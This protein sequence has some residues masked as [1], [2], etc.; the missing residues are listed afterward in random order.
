MSTFSVCKY[1][2]YI[3]YELIT[4]LNRIFLNH[5]SHVNTK[6]RID[7]VSSTY[8]P[9]FLSFSL[10]LSGSLILNYVLSLHF[11]QIVYQDK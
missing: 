7:G 3:V 2:N 4:C 5:F 6:I 10:S 9:V 8:F 11:G 1:Q